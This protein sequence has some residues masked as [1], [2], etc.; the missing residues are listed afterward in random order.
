KPLRATRHF[1]DGSFGMTGPH[2]PSLYDKAGMTFLF[3]IVVV[4]RADDQADVYGGVGIQIHELKSGV[5]IAGGAGARVHRHA[6]SFAR[7][8]D[9]KVI[10]LI[11]FAVILLRLHHEAA[12]SQLAQHSRLLT[13]DIKDQHLCLRRNIHPLEAAALRSA[14]FRSMFCHCTSSPN[15]LTGSTSTGTSFAFARIDFSSAG[16]DSYF[17]NHCSARLR[18]P[19]ASISSNS[20]ASDAIAAGILASSMAYRPVFGSRVMAPCS[21]R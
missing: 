11:V 10:N 1:R 4:I 7:L 14:F 17:L 5:V 21:T 15:A 18:S 12:A 20:L 13:L 6:D 9:R 2:R 8:L 3:L 19:V 16:I